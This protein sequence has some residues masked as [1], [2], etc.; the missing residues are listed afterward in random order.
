MSFVVT[1]KLDLSF[2][3]TEWHAAYINFSLPGFQELLE[4]NSPTEEEIAQDPKK[5]TGEMIALLEKHFIDGK[6]WNGNQ[7]VDLVASDIKEL[8][9]SVFTEATKLVTGTPDPKS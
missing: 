4:Q 6:G 9:M 7:L 8:P 2:L 5:Y 3:G 1:K